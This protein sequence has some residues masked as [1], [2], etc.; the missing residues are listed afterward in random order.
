[1][2]INVISVII[3]VS[4]QNISFEAS[5]VTVSLYHHWYIWNSYEEKWMDS[6][7]SNSPGLPLVSDSWQL[8]KK[9]SLWLV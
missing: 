1:M 2:R 9:N 6:S 4:S 8:S 7:V 3:L 5:L